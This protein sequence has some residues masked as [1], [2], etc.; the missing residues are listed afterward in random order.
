M[1]IFQLTKPNSFTKLEKEKLFEYCCDNS[2]SYVIEYIMN[3]QFTTKLKQKITNRL[4]KHWV[5]MAKTRMG[6]RCL[7]AIYQNGTFQQK[8]IITKTL[9][10]SEKEL[11]KDYFGKFAIIN[12]KV[13]QYLLKSDVWKSTTESQDRKRKMF[14]DIFND[15]VDNSTDKNNNDNDDKE[16]KNPKKKQKISNEEVEENIAE[17]KNVK[18]KVDRSE[19]DVAN[20]MQMFAP[21][22]AKTSDKKKKRASKEIKKSEPKEKKEVKKEKKEKKEKRKSTSKSK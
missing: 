16:E 2:G 15:S 20:I 3:G 18:L 9:S 1:L 22:P 19:N 12:C 17:K 21:K 13:D 8:E 14:E 7:D 10:E 5:A 4:E 6:S 11:K